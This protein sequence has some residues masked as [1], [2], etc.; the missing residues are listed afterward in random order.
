MTPGPARAPGW[1]SAGGTLGALVH[2][3]DVDVRRR[4]KRLHLRSQAHE[5]GMER[6][7]PQLMPSANVLRNRKGVLRATE[8][9]HFVTLSQSAVSKAMVLVG[10]R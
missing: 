1:R 8:L 10:V 2:K 5:C 7:S 4:E 3:A 9:V 6:G